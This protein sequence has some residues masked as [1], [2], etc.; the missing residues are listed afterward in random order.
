VER[1]TLTDALRA[2]AQRV[3]EAL[4]HTEC[5]YYF[6]GSG[7]AADSAHEALVSAAAAA[8]GLS[9]AKATSAIDKMRREGRYHLD[10]WGAVSHGAAKEVKQH[11]KSN[12][13]EK[14]LKA[15]QISSY[16]SLPEV[17]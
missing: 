4:Q 7:T 3:W 17:D 12:L 14:W 6:C 16:G 5:H 13:A 9:R 15:V 1:R 8:S 11:R 10:V 2:D